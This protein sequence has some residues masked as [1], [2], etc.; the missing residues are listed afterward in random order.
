LEEGRS[1]VEDEVDTSP[2]LHH[3]KRGTE[4]GATQVT[5]G[6]PETALEA[7]GPAADP[8]ALRND[9][10]FIFVIGN[11]LCQFLLNVLRFSGLSTKPRQRKCGF[12]NVATLDKISRRLSQE[13]ETSA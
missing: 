7:V 12:L 5:A 8:A 10:E 4:N 6:F 9:L 1:E 2:L 13:E 11:D 3:L